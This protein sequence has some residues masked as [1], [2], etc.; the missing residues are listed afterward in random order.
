MLILLFGAILGQERAPWLSFLI[1]GTAITFLAGKGKRR[2]Q[3]LQFGAAVLIMVIAVASIPQ[4]REKV[5]ARLTEVE[6]E[7]VQHNT[8]LSRLMFWALAW[9]LF[10]EHPVLGVGP[11]NFIT[12]TPSYLTVGEMGGL[13]AADPHNVWVGIL[14][15][16]GLLG[17]FTYVPLC[18]AILA[19]AY[20]R[21]RDPAWQSLRPF[22]LAYLAYHVFMFAM[23]YHYFTKAEGHLHFLMVGLMVGVMR[24]KGTEVAPQ[25]AVTAGLPEAC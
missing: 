15:E 22:L 16:G 21:L 17:F 7:D 23:S 12:L 20:R 3:M 6:I 9:K 4:V 24:W 10:T 18:I 1:S 2:K 11:K 25:P 14:A 19:L 5:V 13:E 8:L